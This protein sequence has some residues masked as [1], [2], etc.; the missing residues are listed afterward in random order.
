MFSQKLLQL[1][2]VQ[3]LLEKNFCSVKPRRK[4]VT[5]SPSLEIHERMK[6]RFPV[7]GRKTLGKMLCS[8]GSQGN[9][10]E[11]MTTTIFLPCNQ[12]KLCEFRIER[13]GRGWGGRDEN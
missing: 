6:G 3:F 7:E 5:N 13:Q 9:A 12:T 8:T 1:N 4:I 10:R 11:I 2:S